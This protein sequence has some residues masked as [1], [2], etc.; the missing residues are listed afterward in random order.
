MTRSRRTSRGSARRRPDAV[1][2]YADAVVGAKVPAGKLVRLACERHLK[3]LEAARDRGLWFEPRSAEDTLEFFRFLTHSKGEWAGQPLELT[4]WQ[5]FIVGTL[6]G[7]KRDDGTRRFRV[8][9]NE[10]P[11]KNGKTTMAAGLG[12]KLFVADGEP[13]AEVYAAAT[14]RDQARILWGEAKRMVKGS[15]A[16]RS[17]VSVLTANLNI[18]M[19]SSKFE[20]LG[21][22]ADTMDGLN[23]H[24]LLI[25]ELHAHKTRSVVDVLETATGARR[26]PLQFEI[27]TAGFDRHSVCWE[28]HDLSV[29]V[30]EGL[31][32][33]D[34]WFAYIATI[35]EGDDWRDPA[36]W[37]KA[38]PN[39]G[40]S[41]KIDDLQRKC[42]KAINAPAAQNAF[43]RL[44]LDEWTEV[45]TLWLP[46]E[47]WDTCGE[48]F[49][50]AMLEGR[51]CYA[52]LDLSTKLDITAFVLV[53][54]PE[55]GD[56][57]WHV[58]PRFWVPKANV[59]ERVRRDR[60]PYDRWIA[61]G[62]IQATEGNVV[63][64]DAVVRQVLDDGQRFKIREIG[65]DSWNAAHVATILQGH[66][67][68]LV[69]MRQGTRTMSGP[70]KDLEAFVRSRRLNHGGNPVLRWMA[71][72]VVVRTDANENYMP[73]KA[74][75]TGRI[76]G[77]VAAIMALG[78][79]LVQVDERSIYETRG[80][81]VL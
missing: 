2:A 64:Y 69:E 18:E 14:K 55:I 75:S 56:E 25:D 28:H 44:H 50:E 70:S 61:E 3:D 49:D 32:E 36:T 48:Q 53:F 15:S 67:F 21:A 80:V 30:L 12:L 4:P 5:Q 73:C 19:T 7:W 78:R 43:R 60:V 57:R 23:P 34:S 20:P 72:N 17:R 11:R 37:A 63:D 16:L 68:E 74:K 1:T 38:N 59:H 66:G 77:I 45:E 26:Q 54:P 52:G 42:R 24:G 35:D 76:D 47:D 79:A 39:L 13:G 65:F 62:W 31:I 22:D 58:L 81:L 29:K 51:I 10:V 27:T 9:Y 40:V 8:A 33:D 6:F 46:M 71:S 41:L